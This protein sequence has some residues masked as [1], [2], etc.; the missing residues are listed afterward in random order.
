MQVTALLPT[1]SR[2]IEIGPT[3][4]KLAEGLIA[5]GYL[6]YVA[7]A[8]DRR[9]GAVLVRKSALQLNPFQRQRP[10]GVGL[11]AGLRARHH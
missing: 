7:V 6:P 9:R 5:A 8:S 2:I 10:R 11:S 4:G 1:E 3:R